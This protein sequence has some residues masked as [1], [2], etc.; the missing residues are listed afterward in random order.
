[1]D[2]DEKFMNPHC[3]H[4]VAS[5]MWIEQVF[6]YFEGEDCVLSEVTICEHK[7]EIG[8]SM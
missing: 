3:I 1:V 7:V 8:K 2:S 6:C 5:I 4:D